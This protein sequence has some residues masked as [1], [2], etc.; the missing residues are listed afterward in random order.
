VADRV[1][2]FDHGR[3]E[4]V[5]RPDE[6]YDHPATS[7]VYGFLGHANQI[8]SRVEHGVAA[9]G[10][11]FVNVPEHARVAGATGTAYI[12]PHDFEIVDNAA[13]AA[14]TATIEH[15]V[16]LGSA[17]RL[18]LV[19]AADGKPLEVELPRERFDELDVPVGSNIQ[20]AVKRARVF[21]DGTAD[22]EEMA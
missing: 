18:E 13:D 17:V 3:V 5:G 14:F 19:D 9:I 10:R 11:A 1:V 20:L 2:L 21:I 15:V 22:R 6:V 8:R 12:R 16:K 4:Q 7:F